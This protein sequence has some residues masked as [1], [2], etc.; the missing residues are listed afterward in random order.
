MA[1]SAYQLEN[2]IRILESWGLTDIILPFLIIFIIMFAT[3]Q[4]TKILG[5]GKRRFNVIFALA[6][7]ALVVVPHV[8]GTYPPQYDVVRMMKESIP[9]VSIIVVAIIM[10]LTIIGVLG[11]ERNWMGGPLSGWVAIA[12]II[13]IIWIF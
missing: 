11:G 13:A 8:L 12:A 4:K 2:F 6:V 10:L 9:N 1:S 3:L 5:E 7:A